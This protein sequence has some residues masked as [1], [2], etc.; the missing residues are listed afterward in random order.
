VS[1]L[2]VRDKETYIGDGVYVRFDGWQIWLRAPR[3]DGDHEIALEPEAYRTLQ[4]WIAS[5][6]DL[7]RHM[8]GREPHTQ[9]DAP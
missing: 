4:R 9:G 1:I 8:T 3:E 5:F 2:P 7:E 6:P